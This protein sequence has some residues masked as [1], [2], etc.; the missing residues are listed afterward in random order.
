MSIELKKYDQ[1][2]SVTCSDF[3]DLSELATSLSRSSLVP[4]HLVGK[5]CDI[6]VTLL[7]GRALRLDPM[8]S[9][10]E[11]LCGQR[12]AVSLGGYD[13]GSGDE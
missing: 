11:I 13:E 5:P 1:F 7:Y 12:E 6:I 8:I 10:R 4:Q 3:K 2:E 9:L